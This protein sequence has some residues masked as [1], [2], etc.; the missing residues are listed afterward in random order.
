LREVSA[1][2]DS[3]RAGKLDSRLPQVGGNTE[4]A[5][6]NRSLNE[7]L[8]SIEGSLKSRNQTLERMKQFVADA[9]HELRTPLVTLR[10]YAELYRKGVIKDKD[11]IDDA[12]NRIESEAIR[13]SE[14]VESLLA[15]ARLDND[16]KLNITEGS[17]SSVIESVV[18]NIQTGHQ[19]AKFSITDL[20]GKPLKENIDWKFDEAA[21]RQV[22]TNLINNAYVF[23]GEKPIEVAIGKD[24]ENLVIEV[25]DHGDGIPKQ[26]RTKIFERFFRSDNSR[27][28]DTGGSGLGLAIAKG[29][30]EGHGGTIVADETPGG[31]ATFRIT[32]PNK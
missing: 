22:L 7:M 15:L 9:S 3:V 20:A 4:I 31:G 16:A 30:V 29:L 2:A 19:E 17:I 24:K 28:R 6:L 5:N 21:I 11:Q 26:L 12:M 14:L 13:M 32:L 18:T 27:N 8:S 10:G 1:A 23:A 25:I